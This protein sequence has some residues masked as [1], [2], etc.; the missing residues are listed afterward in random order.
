MSPTKVVD[1]SD[2]TKT[3]FFELALEQEKLEALLREL[4]TEHWKGITFGPCVPGAVYEIKLQE[5]PKRVSVL[6]GYLT[7]DTGPWHLHLC[8]GPTQGSKANPTPPEAARSRQVSRAAF[9]HDIRPK[10]ACTS[11]SWGLRLWNGDEDQM[12]TFFFPNPYRD[13]DQKRLQ[14][15]DWSRLELWN[16]LT[17]KYLGVSVS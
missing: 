4:F 3:E 10:Q 16:K 6:D 13:D 9:F 11:E 1:N 5:P 17:E 2:G 7:M 15:P 12:I 8:I 14:E